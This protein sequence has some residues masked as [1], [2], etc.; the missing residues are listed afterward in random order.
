M[1]KKPGI[2]DDDDDDDDS[3]GDVGAVPALQG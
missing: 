1:E 3:D 2:D